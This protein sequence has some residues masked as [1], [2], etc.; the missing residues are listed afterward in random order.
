MSAIRSDTP[1]EGVVSVS[2]H[3]AFNEKTTINVTTK[4]DHQ[5]TTTSFGSGEYDGEGDRNSDDVII[6]DGADAANHLLPMRDDG[7]PALTFRSLVLASGLSCFQAVMYQI[8]MVIQSQIVLCTLTDISM[9]SSNQPRSPFKELS[10]SS[11]L[12]LLAEPGPSSSPAE[13]NLRLDGGRGVAKASFPYPS[14]FSNS[15]TMDHGH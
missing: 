8:Y 6:V 1:V 11:F 3:D 12:T 7:D 13:I 15:S 10:S 14:L 9:Y 2:G 4:D 5:V